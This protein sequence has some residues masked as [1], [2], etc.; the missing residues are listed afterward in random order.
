MLKKNEEYVVDII[1]N[2]FQGEGIAKIDGITVFI[3]KAIKGEKI[4]TK[5]VKVQTN[6]AYGIILEIIKKSENREIEEC[7]T[8]KKCGGCNL[9][10][11]KYQE[12][13][14]IKKNIVENCL[15][16]ALKKEIQ[17]NDVIGMELPL[18]Y[19]NKLQYPLGFINKEKVM[20]IY[21][22]RSHN[23]IPTTNCMIQNKL[24]QDVANC[25]FEYIKGNKV[26]V[27]DEE[28]HT[29]TI[30]H[31]IVRIGVKTNEV[32]L[33]LVVNDNRFKEYIEDFVQYMIVKF[34]EIKAIVL[35]YNSQNTNVILGTKCETIFGRGY[36]YD[37]LGEYKFKISPLSF[38]QVN[39]IQTE[40]L[41]RIATENVGVDA[42]ID[43][44]NRIALDLYCGIG[45]IGIFASKYFK[46]VYGIEIV[47]GAIKDAKEN[48]KINN[49]DNMEFY[50][51]DVEEILPK[52][53]EKEKIKPN[54]VFVDPPRKGLDNNT[55]ELLKN[56]EPGK[57]I[58]ISCNPATLARDLSCLEEKYEIKMVQPV[59]MFPYTSHVECV[60]VLYLK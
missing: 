53:I 17:V 32:L 54:V 42:H 46:K 41:Y 8:Y 44:N 34:P 18:Y 51:G 60:T 28:T 24:C 55:I 52:I 13:L 1:D 15:Y 4:K 59:D 43:P 5:I 10:H 12:T 23:I 25:V 14:N 33:T 31:V 29:G 56:L 20:G 6:F 57:I 26:K 38:Y 2:G 3:P 58:Y 48:A 27:Y 11:I 35:N 50:A 49:I 39:P 47:E 45:T 21:S 40:K 19:R 30:R 36:I 37:V 9:R 22:E 7:K 16:K